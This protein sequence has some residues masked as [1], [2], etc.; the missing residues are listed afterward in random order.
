VR[1]KSIPN[2]F[3]MALPSMDMGLITG[4]KKPPVHDRSR[5]IEEW[6][7]LMKIQLSSM[8]WPRKEKSLPES[9]RS[10]M[11]GFQNS[12][13][14]RMGLNLNVHLKS[15]AHPS[16]VLLGDGISMA[17]FYPSKG[18]NEFFSRAGKLKRSN[19]KTP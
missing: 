12:N 6:P 2:S 15:N 3:K 4:P 18:L 5:K 1:W 11:A 19:I 8:N 14:G 7:P 10:D 13:D 9:T 17:W 16:Q